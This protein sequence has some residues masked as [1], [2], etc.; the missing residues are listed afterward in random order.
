MSD[1]GD[2]LAWMTVQDIAGDL[3]VHV[4]TVYRMV[5]A[6]RLPPPVRIGRDSHWRTED[7]LQWCDNVR[8]GR[9]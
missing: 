6:G 5:R 4:S 3:Q 1:P 9:T 7:Y 2:K 8:T